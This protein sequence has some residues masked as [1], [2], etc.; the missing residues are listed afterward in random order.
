MC[1]WLALILGVIQSV[2]TVA[3][4]ES[5]AGSR[6]LRAGL[7]FAVLGLTLSAGVIVSATIASGND[8]GA[9]IIAGC[10]LLA[11][12]VAGGGTVRDLSTAV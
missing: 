8:I 10:G 5:A 2:R 6:R 11:L 9:G 3:A 1:W 4:V 7:W 12:A